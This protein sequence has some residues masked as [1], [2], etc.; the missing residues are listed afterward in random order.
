MVCERHVHV[1][2]DLNG[3]TGCGEYSQVDFRSGVWNEPGMT[4]VPL[5]GPV[6]ELQ[7]DSVARHLQSNHKLENENLCTQFLVLCSLAI[8][9][10]L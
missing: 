3:P 8:K 5:V 2:L 7:H 4:W 10:S 1:S 6:N 9:S